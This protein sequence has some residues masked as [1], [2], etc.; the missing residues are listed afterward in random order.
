MNAPRNRSSSSSSCAKTS[1]DPVSEARALAWTTDDASAAFAHFRPLAERVPTDGLAVFTG[2][3]MVM[4][5][6]VHAA[7]ALVEPHFGLVAEQLRNPRFVDVFELPSLVLA[8]QVAAAR[9][10][11]RA[12]STGEVDAMLSEA[13]PLRELTLGYLEIAAHP[14]LSLVP[15]ERVRAIREGSGKLD[16]AQDCLAISNLFAE[17][18][19]SL[20]G[21]HPFS[22]ETLRRLD[23][24]GSALI[25]QIKPGNAIATA[26][27]RTPESI[28]R[29][30]LAAMVRDR[31]EHLLLMASAALGRAK[32]EALLPSL[33]STAA[34]PPTKVNDDKPA[35]KPDATAS[36]KPASDKPASDKPAVMTDA[37]PASDKPPADKPA[38]TDAPAPAKT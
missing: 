1:A 24:L 19:S 18:A 15:T 29:D 5:A 32:A 4:F 7:I 11:A 14:L 10:P 20:S 27:T 17:Y 34:P 30:Q 36:D 25:Q 26:P 21:Q 9:V 33:H 28:L 6:N 22:A 38:A 13:S 37:K 31:Y 8:L 12:L 3:P 2:Q 23:A 35:A 16:F